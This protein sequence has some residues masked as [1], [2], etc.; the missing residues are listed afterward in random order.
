MLTGCS[1]HAEPSNTTASGAGDQSSAA[2]TSSDGG[3]SSSAASGGSSKPQGSSSTYSSTSHKLIISPDGTPAVSETSSSSTSTTTSETPASSAPIS[4]TPSSSSTT[5]SSVSSSSTP[6]SSSEKPV[7]KPP[8][9]TSGTPVAQHG[10]LSVKGAYLVDASGNK[11]QLRGMST[12]GIGWFPEYVNYDTFKFL[13]DDWNTNCIRLAMYTYENGGYCSDGDKQW[14][15]SLVNNGVDYATQLGMYVIIDWHVLGEQNPLRFKDEAKKFFD[16]MSKKYAN[17]SN[18]LYEICNEPNNTGWGDIKAYA[19]EIIP[20]IRAN[21]PNSV[22]IVGTPTW[23]QEIDQAAASPLQFDN[24]MYTLHFYADTHTDW[25]RSRM[26]TCING[27][28][29]VFISEFGMCDASGNGN[30][31]EWQSEQWKSLIDK[32]NVS[33]MCWNLANKNESSSILRSG[34]SKLYGWTDS[35]LSTQGKLIRKWFVNEKD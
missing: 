27:G 25:L 18:V 26:E 5:S 29:P 13:R 22:I 9:S 4:S 20:V 24:L 8:V 6:A 1:T 15:K 34:C 10:A 11:V 12:H 30:V 3:A 21:D 19:N 33:Y 7:E 14:L 23:S 35:D 28:L 16:E 31:N 2:V 32:Y 17:Y